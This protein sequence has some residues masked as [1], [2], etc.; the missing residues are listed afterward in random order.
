MDLTR[1]KLGVVCGA[2]FIGSRPV[3]AWLREDVCEDSPVAGSRS[4]M[5]FS[6][7]IQPYTGE[8]TQ[9]RTIGAL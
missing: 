5:T 3:D 4:E 6:L 8:A 1:R 7:P 9:E 2:G